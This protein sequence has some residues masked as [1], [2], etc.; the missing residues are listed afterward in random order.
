MGK[1]KVSNRL[2]GDYGELV[3]E[4]FSTQNNYAYIKL[5]EIYHTLTPKNKLVFQYGYQRIVVDIPEEI[6]EEIRQFC[7]PSNQKDEQPSFVYDYFTVSIRNCFSYDSKKRI[8]EQ[9]KPPVPKSFHWV[10]VKTGKSKLSKNQKAY[11]EVSKIGVSVF[12]VPT[13]LPEELEVLW[14]KKNHPERYEE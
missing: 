3:F 10:E 6:T 14:D 13:D 11:K 12:R 1:L 5:E 4:H 7:K 8:Y 2:Q 9:C